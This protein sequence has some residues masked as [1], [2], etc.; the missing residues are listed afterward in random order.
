M[1]ERLRQKTAL[2]TAAGQGIGRAT[3][4]AFAREGARVIA[5]DI[6]GARLAGLIG[7]RITTAVLDVTDPEAIRRAAVAIGPVDVLFNCAGMIH[8][9]TVLDCTESDWDEA[10]TLNARAMYRTIR[11]F[12]PGMLA[13]GSGSIINVASVA[14]SL[15]GV[16]DRFVYSASKAAVIGITRA[17]AADFVS[18]GIRCNVICPGTVQTPSLETRLAATAD[19]AAARRSFIARQPMQRF[20]TPEEI[21]ALAVHLAGDE[22]AF[23]T[24]AIHVVDGGWSA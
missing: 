18:Q 12:L 24:G 21:A 11:A 3:A 6:D 1:V 15:K 13:R 16:P 5:T 20:G 2:V 4:A 17:V 14:S 8:S 10:F 9:G 23:T 22:S 19:P 7:A